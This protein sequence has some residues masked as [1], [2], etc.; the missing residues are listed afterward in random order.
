MLVNQ[1]LS[2]GDPDFL[3]DPVQPD[4]VAAEKISGVIEFADDKNSSRLW[5]LEGLASGLC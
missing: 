1:P 2:P 3:C 5:V 4:P